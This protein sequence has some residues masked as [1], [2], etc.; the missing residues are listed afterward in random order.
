MQSLE[1]FV[2][3]LQPCCWDHG[4]CIEGRSDSE[5]PE[6]LLG[7]VHAYFWDFTRVQPMPSQS[8]AAGSTSADRDVFFESKGGWVAAQ[9]TDCQECRSPRV[10]TA[11]LPVGEAEH[12][13]GSNAAVD[14]ASATMPGST[15]AQ[16]QHVRRRCGVGQL[17]PSDRATGSFT[18]AS[19]I[20]PGMPDEAGT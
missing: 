8:G 18:S 16:G 14:K 1:G 15:L 2:P 20:L 6:V 12:S 10:G 3:R 4:V 11:V 7:G 5:L 19:S 13:W 9:Q 17:E